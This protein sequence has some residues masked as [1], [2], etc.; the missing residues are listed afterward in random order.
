MDLRFSSNIFSP[1]IFSCV[2]CVS[3]IIFHWTDSL[4]I[5]FM[6]T[7]LLVNPAEMQPHSYK[8]ASYLSYVLK[9]IGIIGKAI[10]N[11]KD[12]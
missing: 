4:Y 6:F 2:F 1:P 10:N 7:V 12:Q 8:D 5:I 3:D 11:I 9:I